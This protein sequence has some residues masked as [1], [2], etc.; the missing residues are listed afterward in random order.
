MT[1][2]QTSREAGLT[3]EGGPTP[4]CRGR[5]LGVPGLATA[6]AR[7]LRRFRRDR[8]GV[9]AIEFGLISVPFLGLFC[10]IFETGFVYLNSVG[11]DAAVQTAARN[12]LTGQAQLAGV[13]GTVTNATQF[14]TTYICPSTGA[15]V[16]P[17]FVNCANLIIDVRWISATSSFAA[18]DVTNDFYSNTS[19]Q[20]FCPGG[21]DT[22]TI[23]RVAYPMPVFMPIIAKATSVFTISAGLVSNVPN[24][25]GTYHLLLSTAVFQ[26]EQFNP[27]NYS[28]LPG[29]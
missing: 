24:L 22:I 29:C 21:P 4:A 28:T 15:Q 7:A 9:S 19:N 13:N 26:T 2:P 17:S 23:V 20:K 3:Q 10:A 5:W 25:P 6:L 16:L 1:A 27:A 11:L 8:R 12:F 18:A 14:R